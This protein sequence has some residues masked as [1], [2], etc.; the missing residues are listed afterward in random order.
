M[1]TSPLTETSKT[2]ALTQ[3]KATMLL[4]YTDPEMQ[5]SSEGKGMTKLMLTKAMTSSMAAVEM[6]Y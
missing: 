5:L 4:I 6:T 3:E 2:V 1:T